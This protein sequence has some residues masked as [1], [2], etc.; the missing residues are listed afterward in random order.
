MRFLTL[1]RAWPQVEPTSPEKEVYVEKDHLTNAV[2]RAEIDGL[3]MTMLNRT[4]F[5]LLLPP[6]LLQAVLMWLLA[7]LP[8]SSHFSD[9]ESIKNEQKIDTTTES[10]HSVSLVRPMRRKAYLV[11]ICSCHRAFLDC[12]PTRPQGPPGLEGGVRFLL[13]WYM[14]GRRRS[15]QEEKSRQISRC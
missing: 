15:R 11:P 3:I 2:S 4:S 10:I 12:W 1:T 8:P 13:S 7:S 5:S 6:P 9:E 14:Q